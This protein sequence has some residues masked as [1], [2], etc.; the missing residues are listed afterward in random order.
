MTLLRLRREADSVAASL[1]SVAPL[2]EV[3]VLSAASTTLALG[4]GTPAS[5]ALAL[6]PSSAAPAS[7]GWV[8]IGH[9]SAR[10]NGTPFLL[11]I[12]VLRDRDELLTPSG[13]RAFFSTEALVRV[14]PAP[15]SEKVP[16]CPRCK[17][18]VDANTPSVQCP[19]CQV[20]HHQSEDLPC[21]IYS[22]TCA[23]CDRSTDLSVSYRWTPEEL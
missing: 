14:A 16:S 20:W 15:E 3:S 17:Q 8:A 23:L 19:E 13:A 9:G 6:H 22:P 10:V 11:G 18:P 2:T 21:W 5:D 12:R 7:S 1:W 4:G